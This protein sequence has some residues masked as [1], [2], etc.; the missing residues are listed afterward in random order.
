[1][2]GDCKRNVK[3]VFGVSEDPTPDASGMIDR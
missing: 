2:P 1:M 3:E